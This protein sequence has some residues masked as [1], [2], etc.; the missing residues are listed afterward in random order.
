MVFNRKSRIVEPF[1]DDMQAAERAINEKIKVARGGTH[2]LRAVSDAADYFLK[3]QRS[4][5]RRAVL[6][7]TDNH[8]QPSGHQTRWSGICGRPTLCSAP[9]IKV[10]GRESALKSS[11]VLSPQTAWMQME[12]MTGV[13]GKD[14]RRIW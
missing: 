8:G 13:V 6:I 9:G 3:E 5:R 11:W 10:R 14:R 7:V 2:I 12:S 1:T 4:E